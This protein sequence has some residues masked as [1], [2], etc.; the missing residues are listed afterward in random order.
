MDVYFDNQ[1]I[2]DD[3]SFQTATHFVTIPAG[4]HQIDFVAGADE[5]NAHPL[6]TSEQVLLPCSNYIVIALGS[7]SDVD[8]LVL[9]E[10]RLEARSP[11]RV[12]YLL[13]H[14][15]SDA[16]ALDLRLLDPLDNNNVLALITNTLAF[17]EFRGRRRPPMSM[18]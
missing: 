13:V 10:V 18:C 4:T 9:D 2:L 6:W 11:D 14:G 8:V 7:S 17:G 16:S 12:E 15:A 5:D 3:L 1:R